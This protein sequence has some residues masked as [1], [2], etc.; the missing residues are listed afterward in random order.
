MTCCSVSSP[1]AVPHRTPQP[2]SPAR[3][4]GETQHAPTVAIQPPG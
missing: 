4:Q 2:A 1:N 3:Q